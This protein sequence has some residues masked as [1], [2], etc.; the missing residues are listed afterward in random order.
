MYFIDLFAGAGGLSEGFIREGFKPIVHVEMD[1]NASYSLMTRT[2]Y[3]YLK[4]KNKKEIYTDYLKGKIDRN[5]LYSHIPSIEKQSVINEAISDESISGIF[6]KTNHVMKEKGIQEVDLIIG[7]PPCQA[8]SMIGRGRDP[9]GKA[10]DP[11]NLLYKQ[12]IKFLKKY[13]PKMFI[14]EN[15]EG[16]YTAGKD[17]EG[18]PGHYLKEIKREIDE[19]GYS[20]DLELLDSKDFGVLQSRKRIIIVGW[21]KELDLNYPDFKRVEHSYKLW[22]LLKDLPE[23]QAGEKRQNLSYKPFRIPMYLKETGIRKSGDILTWHEA[24]PHNERDLK[25]YSIAVEAWNK[26]KRRIRYNELPGELITH[27]NQKSFLDRFKVVAGDLSYSHTMV[28]HIAKDGHHFIHPDVVQNR[29]L[30][31]REAARIQSFP[32]D[33]YF[34]GPR[35]AA[36]TQIGNAVPPLMGEYIAKEIKEEFSKI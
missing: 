13:T 3:Y 14:F 19:A 23:L 27:K 1:K 10:N 8:Y 32:D 5:E 24:R 11:K 16:L 30:T 18:K 20:M 15:V 22:D 35:T 33:F 26:E 29:S 7:G 9:E 6:E 21:K 34:E 12:Y 36:Y 17:E 2:A 25:I 4:N 31:V 28:A